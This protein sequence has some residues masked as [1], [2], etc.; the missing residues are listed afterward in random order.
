MTQ[1]STHSADDST[2]AR[3]AARARAVPGYS[4]VRG[5]LYY[6]VWYT[7]QFMAWPPFY[8]LWM[9]PRTLYRVLRDFVLVRD[10][11]ADPIMAY[12]YNTASDL[13]WYDRLAAN[14]REYGPNGY[15]FGDA[16]GTAFGD[17][18]F[19]HTVSYGWLWGTLGPR[20]YALL[21][22]AIILATLLAI[23]VILNQ[24][25]LALIVAL[26]VAG[27][28]AFLLSLFHLSKPENL[29]WSLLPLTL[30][31]ML[32]GDVAGATLSLFGIALT[33]ITMM[34]PAAFFATT[35]WIGGQLPFVSLVI[36]GTPV[37]L[38]VG[39]QFLRFVK[40][41]GLRQFTEVLGGG[42]K[43]NTLNSEVYK[44]Y[45]RTIVHGQRLWTYLHLALA[46]TLLISGVPVGYVLAFITPCV[47]LLINYRLFRWADQT[48]FGRLYLA[49]TVVY[50]LLFPAPLYLAGVLIVL[51]AVH[52]RLVM[53]AGGLD[54]NHVVGGDVLANYPYQP[55]RL[56]QAAMARV[57]QC[58]A[59][60]PDGT[61]LAWQALDPYGANLAGY[62]HFNA[63]LEKLLDERHIEI[64]PGIWLRATQTNWY[65][66]RWAKLDETSDVAAITATCQSAGVQYL[67]VTTDALADQLIAGG[68][69]LID[70]LTPELL[71]QTALGHTNTPD[72]LVRLLRL[73]VS[74]ALI[75]PAVPL[76]RAPNRLSFQAQAG[77]TYFLKYNYHP[78][79]RGQ[80]AG[81][82]IAIEQAERGELR[83]MAI[84]VPTTGLVQLEFHAHWLL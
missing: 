51:L 31:F 65:A 83:G 1:T 76:D 46:L 17:R 50:A 81:Q 47:L 5:I 24:I 63:L 56:G 82:P 4:I 43:S 29:G 7:R 11:R 32:R 75:E 45:L 22:G 44:A 40:R 28:P 79:W 2:R 33:S 61:R 72:R 70:Q 53:D 12:A 71:K 9:L 58:F 64:L 77:T 14:I 55:I 16:L 69:E 37:A 62:R 67:I 84:T 10:E 54:M 36:I 25:G 38:K 26:I 19:Q 59:R 6:A 15:A 20:R 80:A 39:W 66:Q 73:P 30:F 35:L 3:W 42:G 23:G 78:A 18:F 27:S 34:V 74:T 8:L 57:A 68:Y 60:V 49:V 48:T 52:P 21:A 13:R 41:V